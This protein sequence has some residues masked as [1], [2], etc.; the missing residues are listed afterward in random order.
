MSAFDFSRRRFLADGGAALVTGWAAANLPGVRAALA[1]ARRAA[2][3]ETSTFEFFTPEEGADV[4]AVA[5]HIWPA[6]D[7]PGASD[8]GIA[9]FIDHV[10]ATETDASFADVNFA[11]YDSPIGAEPVGGTFAPLVRNGLA[12][13]ATP[14]GRFATR[15]AEQ[16]HQSLAAIETTAF[17][18]LLRRMT[19]VGLFADP[20]HGGNAAK[21]GWRAIGFED[22]FYWRPPFGA[23]DR[24]A[25]TG[26]GQ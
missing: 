2:T 8:A 1:H 23:Y 9:H 13:L 19:V 21:S 11:I 6:D 20:S 15:P 26:E 14:A 22:R 4:A 3:A 5:A 25:H 17:F 18:R 16:Q 10:F 12:Q 7:T 24:D